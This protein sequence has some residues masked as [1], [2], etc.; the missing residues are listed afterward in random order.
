VH[1]LVLLEDGRHAFL[2]GVA[3]DPIEHHVAHLATGGRDHHLAGE[4]AHIGGGPL[5]VEP[6]EH[7]E[8][9]LVALVLHEVHQHAEQLLGGP[10]GG[11]GGQE[12]AHEGVGVVGDAVAQPLVGQAHQVGEQPG[13]VGRPFRDEVPAVAFLAGGLA[14]A[15]RH[16]GVVGEA[17]DQEGCDPER[18]LLAAGVA[19]AL[20]VDVFAL[21]GHPGG[22]GP[23]RHLVAGHVEGG[24][25]AEVTEDPV[26]GDLQAVALEPGEPDLQV[27]AARHRRHLGGG[28]LRLGLGRGPVA[29]D[30]GE[31]HAVHVGVLRLEEALVVRGVGPSAQTAAHHLLAQELRAERPHAQDVGDGVGVPALGEHGHRDHAADLLAELV[32]ACP[33]CSSPR[34]AGPRR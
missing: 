2:P 33:P 4:E 13:A 31:R 8:Q 29:G 18:H 5:G 27:L 12:Q 15:Q 30:E 32:P 9:D 16:V 3:L 14:L 7:G 25:G 11:L 21:A 17:V 6:L 19:V 24:L 26:V 23:H 1:Q 10:V 22:L 20:D 34:A 28:D